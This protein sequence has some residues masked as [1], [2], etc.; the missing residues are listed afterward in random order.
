MRISTQQMRQS[1]LTLMLDQQARLDKTQ[2][3]M[4][5]GTRIQTAADDPVAAV[6][7]M[8]L[9]REIAAIEQYQTNAEAIRGRQ[10]A[11]ENALAGVTDLIHSVRELMV[12]ANSDTLSESNRQSLSMS[13]NQK[14]DELLGLAN[15]SYTD[16]EYLFSGFQNGTQPFSRDGQGKVTYQGDQGQRMLGIGPGVTAAMTDSGAEVFQQ[17]RAGNGTFVTAANTANTGSGSISAGQATGDWEAGRYSLV[18]A[19]TAA[20]QPVTYE[21]LDVSTGTPVVSGNYVSGA[22]IQFKG[23]EVTVTGAPVDG[24]SFSVEP[25]GYRDLF[26]IVQGAAQALGDTSGGSAAQ[27]QRHTALNRGL[28]ELNGALDH[29]LQQRARVG[30]RLNLVES[31]TLANDAFKETATETLSNVQDLDYAEATTRLQTQK[32]ILEASQQ[33][34]VS[35]QGLSLFKFLS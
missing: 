2:R 5:S 7:A 17:I 6:R 29:V 27:A 9:T 16:G 24:D 31:Q 1:A 21:V 11:E 33:S 34:Y 28:A 8:G 13:L 30:S 10:T 4:A 25:A 19:Q 18:F 22:S 32:L 26:A 35:I 3:Q 14:V 23:A 15:T 12:Q 20:D